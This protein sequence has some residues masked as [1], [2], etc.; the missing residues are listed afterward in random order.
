MNNDTTF[1]LLI[2]KNDGSL[3]TLNDEQVTHWQ[4]EQ[5]ILWRHTCEL[6][7]EFTSFLTEYCIP[8]SDISTLLSTN[9]RPNIEIK[10][11]YMLLRLNAINLNLTS[12]ENDIINIHFFIDKDKIVSGCDKH[13]LAIKAISE[14]I[15]QEKKVFSTGKFILHFCEKLL[16]RKSLLVDELEDEMADLESNIIENNGINPQRNLANIRRQS[17]NIRRLLA[18]EKEV[19]QQMIEQL[20][21]LASDDRFHMKEIHNNLIRIIDDVDAVRDRAMVTQEELS[22]QQSE[23]LNKRLY[24]LSLITIIFLPLSFL[25]GLFGVNLGGIPG[26]N[27]HHAFLIFNVIL[28][29]LLIVQI[30]V[31]YRTHW[32]KQQ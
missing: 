2:N 23:Q 12:S 11:N 6:N 15:N 18:P 31:L 27:Y 7:Q 28:A 32:F 17:I 14:L 13:F 22:N 3:T 29:I 25:T 20:T 9:N 19:Y 10:N 24:L 21:L 5:G 26:V 1:S 4:P 30:T 16:Q 8:T